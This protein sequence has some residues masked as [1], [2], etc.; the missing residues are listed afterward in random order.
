LREQVESLNFAGIEFPVNMKDIGK[1]EKNSQKL[2][3]RVARKRS[4]E[5]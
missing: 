4:T 3:L 5:S 2:T 1:F